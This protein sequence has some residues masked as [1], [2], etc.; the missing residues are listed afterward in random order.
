VRDCAGIVKGT[1]AID[2]CG[3]CG[4]NNSTCLDCA[5]I[6][7]G[8]TTID[9]CGVCGGDNSTCTDCAGIAGGTAVV[10]SCGVCGGDG[11]SCAISPLCV[12]DQIDACGVCNGAA[13]NCLDCAGIPNGKT[14]YD[15]CGVCGGNGSSCSTCYLRPKTSAATNKQLSI[16]SADLARLSKIATRYGNEAKK[17]KPSTRQRVQGYLKAAG[18]TVTS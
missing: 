11:S 5:G 4:G 10:D 3:V 18:R 9:L 6:P 8:G 7:N 16:Y 14:E 1:T 17:C 13:T 15:P 12:D 2:Q